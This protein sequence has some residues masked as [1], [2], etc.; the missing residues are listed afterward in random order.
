MHVV[1]KIKP[2]ILKAASHSPLTFYKKRP[3]A[4]GVH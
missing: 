4:K 3:M 2:A 1:G